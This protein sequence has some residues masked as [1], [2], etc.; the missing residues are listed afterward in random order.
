MT[1]AGSVSLFRSLTRRNSTDDDRRI[2][3]WRMNWQ[4][5]A[6]ARWADQGPDANPNRAGSRTAAAWSAGWAWAARHPDR[7]REVPQ[8]LAH[9]YRRS[10][11][12]LIR[13][14][15]QPCSSAIGL[16]A[17]TVI[18]GLWAMRRRRPPRQ[19]A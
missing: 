1:F 7:R 12:T 18:G 13:L 10:N 8:G 15:R 2:R 6:Q 4:L 11:D 17:I 14:I 19:H 9:P 16:S 3:E 5:G